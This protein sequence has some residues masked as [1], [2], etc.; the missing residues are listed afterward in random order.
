MGEARNQQRYQSWPGGQVRQGDSRRAQLVSVGRTLGSSQRWAPEPVPALPAGSSAPSRAVCP[1]D[2][3]P[4]AS[5]PEGGRGLCFTLSFYG[6]RVCFEKIAP[7]QVISGTFSSKCA[8]S[9]W[10]L[11]CAA[12]GFPGA[13]NSSP[14]AREKLPSR[15]HGTWVGEEGRAQQVGRVHARCD[16][17]GAGPWA[18][19]PPNAPE[20]SWMNS[21]RHR[22]RGIKCG[23]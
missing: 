2:T 17:R 8:F 12:L 18:Q 13:S 6:K 22:S 9:L 1:G 20:F 21:L 5:G 3:K 10:W 11:P 19:R 15:A 23:S 7:H 4:W 16:P 14:E